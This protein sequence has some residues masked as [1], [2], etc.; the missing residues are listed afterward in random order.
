MYV[1]VFVCVCVCMCVSVCVCVF[2]DVTFV[3]FT[4]CE[5]CTRPIST[6]SGSM[7]AGE[8]GRTSGTCLITCRLEVVAVTGLLWLFW[9]VLGG[10]NFFAFSMSLHF[11][12]RRPRAVSVDLAKGLRQ[13]ANL[14]TEN[15][16]PLIPTRC[17][18]YCAST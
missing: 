3:V 13:P 2:V 8:C 14:P 4:D 1:C 10:V 7:E 15:S 6:N 12:I 5:S 9:C 18:V 16:R 17:T 11:K